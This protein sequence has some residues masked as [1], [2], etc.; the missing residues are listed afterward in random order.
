MSCLWDILCCGW[1]QIIIFLVT[2]ALLLMKWHKE[3]TLNQRKNLQ[4]KWNAVGKD[5][6][7]LHQFP[8]ARYCPN[9]SPYPI[10]LETFLRLHDINYVNDFEEPMS[11]KGKSPWI[12]LNGENVA[13]SQIIICLL[14]TSPS[15]RDGLL[16]R[17]PSS[18]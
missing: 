1:V 15:P 4:I 12:T 18:A 3:Q 16:S 6:V 17:M 13:D 11:D 10:K 9:P 5:V 8:R 7:I 14:Y 2:C